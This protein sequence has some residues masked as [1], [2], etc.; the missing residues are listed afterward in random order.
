MSFFYT[1]ITF[2]KDPRPIT[3]KILKSSKFVYLF[4]YSPDVKIVV[5]RCP[6]APPFYSSRTDEGAILTLKFTAVS[7]LGILDT[8]FFLSF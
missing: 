3:F 6:G 8:F 1:N 7:L 2:P 5:D 4:D